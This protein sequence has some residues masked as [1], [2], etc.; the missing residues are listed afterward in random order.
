[1]SARYI[2]DEPVLVVAGSTQYVHCLVDEKGEIVEGAVDDIREESHMWVFQ[3]DPTH[4]T[5]D[6]EIQEVSFG[7]NVRVV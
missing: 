2:G 4:E 7:G 3:Q 5:R 6:W 1:M